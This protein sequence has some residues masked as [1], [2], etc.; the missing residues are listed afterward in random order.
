MV[1]AK[2]KNQKGQAIVEALL[3][4]I[5]FLGIGLM[6]MSFFKDQEVLA[7]LV[8]GPWQSLSGV[9]QN[10]TWGEPSKTTIMHPN[11]HYRH[12]SIRGEDAK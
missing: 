5:I 3:I 8:K 9:L 2:E 1:R 11:T 7:K 12:V 4:M 6:V 10:G